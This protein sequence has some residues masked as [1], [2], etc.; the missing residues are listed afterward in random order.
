MIEPIYLL[1]F[2]KRLPHPAAP[3]AVLSD[4]VEGGTVPLELL[5][6]GLEVEIEVSADE[7]ADVGVFVVAD[8]GLGLGGA[9]GVDVHVHGCGRNVREKMTNM[10]LGVFGGWVT[11]R[12]VRGCSNRPE[13]S[14]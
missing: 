14:C 5:R 13:L 1:P 3:L 11:Y 10:L 9:G 2:T 12:N 4:R 7:V 8:E 6:D